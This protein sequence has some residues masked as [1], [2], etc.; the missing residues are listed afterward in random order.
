[1]H[2]YHSLGMVTPMAA[3][4]AESQLGA[5]ELAVALQAMT[6]ERDNLEQRNAVLQRLNVMHT[7][8]STS[9]DEAQVGNAAVCT[10]HACST[11]LALLHTR[12]HCFST[13]LGHLASCH[14]PCTCLGQS[15]GCQTS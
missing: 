7:T 4:G 10:K 3:A 5:Q 11:G 12:M 2:A 13:C 1:M 15:S 14:S 6:E 8:L 9:A